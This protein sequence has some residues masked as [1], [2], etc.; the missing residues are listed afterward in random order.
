MNELMN[1]TIAIS[2]AVPNNTFCATDESGETLW[3]WSRARQMPHLLVGGIFTGATVE[4]AGRYS[5][6]NCLEDLSRNNVT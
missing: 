1:R 2:D 6:L 3:S 5:V 4:K